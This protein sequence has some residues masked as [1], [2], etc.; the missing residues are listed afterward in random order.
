MSY[1]GVA[2][3]ERAEMLAQIGAII[4]AGETPAELPVHVRIGLTTLA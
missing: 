3:D 4:D 1:R 2:R